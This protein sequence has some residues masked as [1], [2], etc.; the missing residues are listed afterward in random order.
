M[1]MRVSKRMIGPIDDQFEIHVIGKK[2]YGIIIFDIIQ[3][4]WIRRYL[5]V[6]RICDLS[7]KTDRIFLILDL[8]FQI[9]SLDLIDNT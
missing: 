2:I 5:F 9:V 8:N 4:L 1:N 6:E 3:K 7:V